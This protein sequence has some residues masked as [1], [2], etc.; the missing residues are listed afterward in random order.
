MYSKLYTLATRL[1]GNET[2]KLVQLRD[3]D[4][5]VVVH[6]ARLI[7]CAKLVSFT[8]LGAFPFSFAGWLF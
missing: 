2:M 1:L 6:R 5:F 3:D 8:G 4:E 7:D